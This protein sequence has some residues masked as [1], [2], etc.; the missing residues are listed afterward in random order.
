MK[1]KRNGF[2]LVELLAVII[3]LA[4]IA[5]IA[6]PIIFNVI[7]NAKIKSLENSNYGVIDAVRTKYAE[8]LLNSNDGN[9][10]IGKS[11]LNL[12]LSGEKPISGAWRINNSIDSNKSGVKIVGVRF[13]S[14]KDYVCSNEFETSKVECKKIGENMTL[15]NAVLS[16]ELEGIDVEW[17]TIW[18]TGDASGLFAQTVGNE[19]TYYFRG[20][21]ENNYIKFAGLDWRIIRVNE[22]GSIRLILSKGIENNQEYQFNAVNKNSDNFWKSHPY[23]Y[24]SNSGEYIQKTIADWYAANIIGTDADKVVS[25]G[26]FCEAAQVIYLSH[27]VGDAKPERCENY[28]PTFKCVTDGNGKGSIDIKAG[29]L[30]YDEAV[31]AGGWPKT[32][33]YSSNSYY[34]QERYDYWTMSP[35]GFDNFGAR[36]W[37]I[38][39]TWGL[40][41]MVTTSS[42]KVRPVINID[43]STMVSG[44][45]TVDSPY[46]VIN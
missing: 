27:E 23:T 18:K 9:I 14:M 16:N 22:D 29:L 26:K 2:T 28:K 39:S 12:T 6:T 7:E 1:K 30:M 20:K 10:P 44:I 38:H 32:G 37:T 46:I 19:T 4:I 31:Y 45:G 8:N 35:A 15:E 41:A 21:P 25:N 33:G 42:Y 3:V 5:L 34:L 13:D 24:Y 36:E 11:A 43:G 40:N 17:T